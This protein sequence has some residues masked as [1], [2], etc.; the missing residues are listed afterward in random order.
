MKLSLDKLIYYI[1]GRVW[2]FHITFRYSF[3][4]GQPNTGNATRTMTFYTSDRNLLSSHRQLKKALV[5]DFVK[6][7]SKQFRT[8]GTL[9]VEHITYVG[10]FKPRA[11]DPIKT[12]KI[13][14]KKPWYAV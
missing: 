9:E 7:L 1:T 13:G 4:P 6:D 14:H 5:P 3:Q 12:G 10:W 8:N 2:N 11:P